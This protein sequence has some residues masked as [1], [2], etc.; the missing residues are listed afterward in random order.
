MATLKLKYGRFPKR[1]ETIAQE[2][3]DHVDTVRSQRIAEQQVTR[4]IERAK[5]LPDA[6]QLA[7]LMPEASQFKTPTKLCGGF[8]RPPHE[9]PLIA[10]NFHYRKRKGSRQRNGSWH[11]LC[12]QCKK[13]KRNYTR[14]LR[15]QA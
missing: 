7:G 1:I 13:A 12:R 5:R 15:T 4:V 2:V 14:S 3:A 9:L 11:P 6:E 8:N 10:E